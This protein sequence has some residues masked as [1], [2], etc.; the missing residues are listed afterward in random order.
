[1]RIP[2]LHKSEKNTFILFDKLFELK[3]ASRNK[4]FHVASTS[5]NYKLNIFI[6]GCIVLIATLAC[7]GTSNGVAVNLSPTP[8]VQWGK[9]SGATISLHKELTCGVGCPEPLHVRID[10]ILI[11]KAADVMIWNAHFSAPA[12][13]PNNG[14]TNAS[15]PDFSLQS[16]STANT[17]AILSIYSQG[18]NILAKFA[19]VPVANE[20]YTLSVT[21][22]YNNVKNGVVEIDSNSL[23]YEPVTMTFQP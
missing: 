15:F 11:N 2:Y 20:E 9:L 13:T 22:N 14:I 12:D 1:M 18:Q 17:Q 6:V 10:T 5:S 21:A 8:T 23:Q 3:T 7:G 16:N 19:F 4:V